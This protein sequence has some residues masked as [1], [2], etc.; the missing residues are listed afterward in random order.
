MS[1]PPVFIDL[2]YEAALEAARAQGRLLLVDA[3]AAWCGPCKAMDRTTWVDPAVTDWIQQHAIAIQIDVDAEPAV[4]KQLEIRAMPTVI[5]VKEGVEVDRAVGLKQP[6]EMRSWLDGVLRGE[7]SLAKLQAEVAQQST[8]MMGRMQLARALASAG[9][10][11]EA[12]DAYAWLWEH[13]VEHEP[14]MFGVRASFVLAE[15]V[16]LCSRHASARTRFEALRDAAA[17]Q[18]QDVLDSDALADWMLLNQAL[19]EQERT[20]AWFDRERERI[21]S[22]RNRNRLLEI[23]LVPLLVERERWAD[24]GALYADPVSTVRERHETIEQVAGVRP[25]AMDDVTFE[26]VRR[27]VVEQFQNTAGQVHRCL[28]AAG[29]LDDA[30]RV[31]SAVREL[32]PTVSLQ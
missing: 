26:D 8:G 4:A 9:K 20:L 27:Q 28:V 3:S 11:D 14:A 17:P 30:A 13:M 19:G 10:L 21:T 12:T 23:I 24:A 22:D 1:K 2:D 5:A 16:D 6:A 15:I 32:D 29:R 7:T 18:P 25:A 31:V